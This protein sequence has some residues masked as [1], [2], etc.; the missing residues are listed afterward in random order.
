[1][2]SHEEPNSLILNSR[3]SLRPFGN[4]LWIINTGRAILEAVEHGETV[5]ASVG[6]SSWEILLY[7][8]SRY[9]AKL[10]IFAPMPNDK[11]IDEVKAAIK[12]DFHLDAD[13]IEWRLI[14]IINGRDNKRKFQ[15]ERDRLILQEAKKAYPVSIRP[16]GNLERHLHEMALSNIS[17]D[18]K[19]RIKYYEPLRIC[20]IVIDRKRINSQ[21]DTILDNYLIHWTRTSNGRW[22]GETSYQFYDA[23]VSSKDRYPRSA[24]DTLIR[25]MSE[26]KLRASSRHYRKGAGAVPFSGLKPSE[27]SGLMRW[28]ARY[29]EM[30][31]EPYGIAIRAEYAREMGIRKVYYGQSEMFQY[32]DEIDKPYFQNIGI[33]GFWMPEKEYRYI[34]DFD[35][36]SLCPGMATIIVLHKEEIEK[37]RSIGCLPVVSYYTD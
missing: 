22:P 10:K 7:F 31:F 5:L 6:M 17:I 27:A 35:L 29:Q 11:G 37:V 1:M 15:T 23:I 33:K 4:D 34:G 3:Q 9:K 19:Y 32:L 26:N 36:S 14:D 24:F 18:E 28:R 30:T 25:I 8:A 16:G 21:I 12:E 13:R 2:I 20:K